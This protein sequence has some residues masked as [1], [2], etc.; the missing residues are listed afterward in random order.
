MREFT[1]KTVAQIK[2]ETPGMSNEEIV[3]VHAAQYDECRQCHES[4]RPWEV[5]E[6]VDSILKEHGLEIVR[7]FNDSGMVE[8]GVMHF[9]I[10]DY[11]P[12]R[13]EKREVSYLR[14][15]PNLPQD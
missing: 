3:V 5:L 10:E 6:M 15:V 7:G 14:V 2:T 4:E 9:K 13:K 1:F 8:G 11:D 12:H